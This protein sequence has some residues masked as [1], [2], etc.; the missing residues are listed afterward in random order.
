VTDSLVKAQTRGTHRLIPPEQTLGM[1]QRHLGTLGV[2]RCADV[3]GLDF[4]RIPVFCA[5]RPQ[6][7]L[8]QVSNGK[9]LD[10]AA[11][12]VSALMEAVEYFHYEH[13][14]ANC[15]RA[16]LAAM[17]R[18]G[19]RA[20]EP[21][22]FPNYRSECFFT[23]EYVIDWE[24]GSELPGGEEAWLPASAV[25]IQ[26]PMLYRFSNNGLASGN[27]L[28]E[29]SLHGLYELIERDAVS[30]LSC[31]GRIHIDPPQ[32]TC[33]DLDSVDDAPVGELVETIRRAGV[34][35]V[36]I[37]VMSCIPV[38]T[39]WAV[40]LDRNPFSHCSTVN[41]GY[42]THLS[43]SVAAA[44]AITEAA[45]S[46]L[47]F[48]HGAREDLVAGAYGSSSAQSRL[49]A[50]FDALEGSTDWRSF[51]D[52]SGEDLLQDYRRVLQ[53]LSS[54]GHRNILRVDMTRPELNIPVVR[55]FVPGLQFN[56]SFF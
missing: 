14:G 2:T 53:W 23:P 1:L 5:I 17:R 3:T 19:R 51:E 12:R 20:F 9:G 24:Q 38:H 29:A 35:L 10:A 36:L 22:C 26:T 56:A 33:V 34:K 39:F 46:R 40:L 8:L 41:T 7:R 45:Q 25:R 30:R 11:A 42:G 47:T 32:A 31:D 6:G 49:F 21:A 52:E 13:T 43:P 28:I 16:S 48:I 50:F 4:L 54:A 27:H 15:R 37:W 18:E 44:R 55:M